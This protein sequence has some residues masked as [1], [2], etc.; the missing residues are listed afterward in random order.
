MVGDKHL[1]VVQVSLFVL[2]LLHLDRVELLEA[3]LV[4]LHTEVLLLHRKAQRPPVGLVG[5]QLKQLPTEIT[6]VAFWK[7][8]EVPPEETETIFV[9][10]Q[11]RFVGDLISG[12]C[13]VQVEN[14]A[15]FCRFS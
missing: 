3:I 2:V 13:I 1:P 6:D 4:H 14:F 8:R 5:L 7:R 11:G 10:V 12:I 15:E 9:L